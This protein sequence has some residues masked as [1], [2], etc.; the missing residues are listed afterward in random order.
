MS[1]YLL[2]SLCSDMFNMVLAS[3]AEDVGLPASPVDQMGAK[4]S[5]KLSLPVTD[6][7]L[8]ACVFTF[9]AG[10]TGFPSRKEP[11]S[12]LAWLIT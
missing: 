4:V 5:I 3:I 8:L 1:R 7:L 6:C 11:N 12:S 9:F 10:L 2:R